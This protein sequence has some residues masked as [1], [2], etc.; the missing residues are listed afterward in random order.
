MANK[1]LIIMNIL[2]HKFN[3]G[4]LELFYRYEYRYFINMKN[5]YVKR[6]GSRFKNII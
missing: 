1:G 5:K 2:T 4:L 3:I 6:K